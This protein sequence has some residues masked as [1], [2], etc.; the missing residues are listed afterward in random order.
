M[1]VLVVVAI[2]MVAAYYQSGK[3]DSLL[4]TARGRITAEI[5]DPETRGVTLVL[6][7]ALHN[8]AIDLTAPRDIRGRRGISLPDLEPYY[9]A[10]RS[11]V[12]EELQKMED[13]ARFFDET[14]LMDFWVRQDYESGTAYVVHLKRDGTCR[15]AAFRSEDHR[16]E[17]PSPMKG[18]TWNYKAGI[19][20]WRGGRGEDDPNQVV[21]K[22]ILAFVLKEMDGSY[23]YFRRISPPPALAEKL[24]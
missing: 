10:L 12:R 5:A 18:G 24:R 7:R 23:T 16:Y 1:A 6:A 8:K 21:R 22:G 20:T 19:L 2:C 9:Q 17:D 3:A 13:K 11:L 15:D 4:D 14:T